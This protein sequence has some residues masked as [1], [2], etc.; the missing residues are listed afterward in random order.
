[1]FVPYQKMKILRCLIVV[2]NELA[3]VVELTLQFLSPASVI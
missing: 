3:S 1:M 2:L